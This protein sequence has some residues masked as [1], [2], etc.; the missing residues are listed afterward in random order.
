MSD[1]EIILFYKYVRVDQALLQELKRWQEDLGESLGLGGRVLL[2]TEGIN[3][4]VCGTKD[5]ISEFEAAIEAH[6]SN[7]FATDRRI[8]WKHSR[9][10]SQEQSSV[11]PDFVVKIVTEIVA[12][13]ISSPETRTSPG[14]QEPLDICSPSYPVGRHLSPLEFHHT[15]LEGPQDKLVVVDVRNQ[16]EYDVGHFKG[17]VSPGMR[18]TAQWQQF[19]GNNLDSGCALRGKKVLLYC[20]GGIRCEKASAY[21]KASGCEDV[22]QLSGG[23]HRYLEEFGEHGLFQGKNFV[24]DKR[25]AAASSGPG[26]ATAD[27]HT[28]SGSGL[29]AAPVESCLS[30]PALAGSGGEHE[31][32]DEGKSQRVAAVGECSVCGRQ[33]SE[34]RGGALCCVCRTLVLVCARCWERPPAGAAFHCE[35]H[36]HLRG[37]YFYFLDGFSMEELRTQQEALQ[38][39]LAE[40]EGKGKGRRHQRRTLRNKLDHIAKR[41]KELEAGDAVVE[42]PPVRRCRSCEK[43]WGVDCIGNCWGFWKE[44]S[45]VF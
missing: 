23:I 36:G 8:D 7:L 10:V 29:G 4:T 45:P 21:L 12:T 32:E 35:A 18:H 5:H 38:I 25:M 14:A 6:S 17:A 42:N 2:A 26:R 30:S 27:D 43:V 9:V 3:G 28:V 41:Q 31:A 19:V 34:H 22:S 24:F 11:F 37:V 13:G 33:W 15:L 44:T 40:E 20:T 39:M 16:Y 1:I